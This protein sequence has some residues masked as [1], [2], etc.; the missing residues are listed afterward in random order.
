MKNLLLLL[1]L[2]SLKL[3]AQDNKAYLRRD[4]TI[5]PARV[6]SSSEEWGL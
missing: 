2:L 4:V 6:I 3:Y 5:R 1:M